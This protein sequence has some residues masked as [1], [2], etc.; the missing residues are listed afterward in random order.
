[1]K[2]RLSSETEVA[3]VALQVAPPF[4]VD[5]TRPIESATHPVE[6]S[7]KSTPRNGAPVFVTSGFHTVP[8]STVPSTSPRSPAI[9]P[10]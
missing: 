3:W 7:T 4:E 9:H 5:S 6:A 10:V 2:S 1:M 8:P